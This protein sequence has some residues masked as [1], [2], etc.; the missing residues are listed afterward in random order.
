MIRSSSIESWQQLVKEGKVAE[1]MARIWFSLRRA[2]QQTAR[3]LWYY[4][5]NNGLLLGDGEQKNDLSSALT[6]LRDFGYIHECP[7]KRRDRYSTRKVIVWEVNIDIP[8][9]PP[10]L[11]LKGEKKASSAEEEIRG[12]R[13]EVAYWKTRAE[14]CEKSRSRLKT[15]NLEAQGQ[16]RLI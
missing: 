14:V 16:Q 15:D 12:L 10:I 3:E 8:D 4:M 5:K 13:K 7:P 2:G 6:K 11:N 9:H 1:K